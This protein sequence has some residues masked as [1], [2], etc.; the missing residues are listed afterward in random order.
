MQRSDLPSLHARVFVSQCC[1]HSLSAKVECPQNGDT[2][3]I[4]MVPEAQ[5]VFWQVVAYNSHSSST[6]AGPQDPAHQLSFRG[7]RKNGHHGGRSE[8]EA[9]H[10][11]APKLHCDCK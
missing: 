11:R 7:G 4:A 9:S 8:V 2:I 1:L 3:I 5:S 10:W 6:W